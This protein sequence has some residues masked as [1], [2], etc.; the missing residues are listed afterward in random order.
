MAFSGDIVLNRCD[1]WWLQ[2]VG[3]GVRHH[4]YPF[5]VSGGLLSTPSLASALYLLMSRFVASQYEQVC[6]VFSMVEGCVTDLPLSKEETGILTWLG[7]LKH[8][9]HPDAVACRLRINLAS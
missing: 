3:G 8:D 6:F 7:H 1:P 2:C 5:H 9:H 4:L